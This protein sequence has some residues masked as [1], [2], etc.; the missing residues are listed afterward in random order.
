MFL[1]LLFGL[2]CQE[3]QVSSENYVP[4][5]RQSTI[6]HV[7]GKVQENS[8]EEYHTGSRDIF[9]IERIYNHDRK[10]S[11]TITLITKDKSMTFYSRGSYE[12]IKEKYENLELNLGD[13][14]RVEYIPSLLNDKEHVYQG[15]EK[16]D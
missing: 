15:I 12:I 4:L 1:V 2:G 9:L 11:H 5:K 7:E 13:R 8:L 14:V 6:W 3:D 16:I 10:A